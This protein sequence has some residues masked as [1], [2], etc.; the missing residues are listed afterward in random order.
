MPGL[1]PPIPFRRRGRALPGQ[2]S[3]EDLDATII[4]NVKEGDPA[5]SVINKELIIIGDEA[6]GRYV[7][8]EATGVTLF[9]EENALIQLL[10]ADGED[11]IGKFYAQIDSNTSQVYV[12]SKGKDASNPEALVFLQAITHDGTAHSGAAGV[13]IQA[14]TYYDRITFDAGNI[15][16]L[17]QFVLKS[18]TTTQRNALSPV[19]G[20]LIYNTTTSKVQAYAGGA[21]VDL[22]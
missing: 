9:M 2:S 10:L 5:A 6:A 20:T 7:R 14:S 12:Y 17:G 22:H 1:K 19:N 3:D 15:Y 4:V 18:Y 13:T 16:A 11:T 21:W 8:I